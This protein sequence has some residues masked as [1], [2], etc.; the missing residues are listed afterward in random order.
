MSAE[1]AHRIGSGLGLSPNGIISMSWSIITE[2]NS[3]Y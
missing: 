2:N 1:V 3:I